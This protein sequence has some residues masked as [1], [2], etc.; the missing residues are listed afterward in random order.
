MAQLKWGISLDRIYLVFGIS[1]I[2]IGAC[3]I[4]STTSKQTDFRNIIT[5]DDEPGDADFTS[6]KEAVNYSSPGDTI[7]VYSG[8]YIEQGIHI[9]NDNIELLGISHELG[10]GND[11]G[12]PFI[13][14]DGTIAAIWIGASHVI[15]SNFSIEN[16]Y[17]HTH[18]HTGG[19]YIGKDYPP[20]EQDDIIIS[21]CNINNTPWGIYDTDAENIRIINNNISNCKNGI[22]IDF[23]MN[24]LTKGNVITDCRDCGIFFYGPIF[25]RNFSGNRIRNCEFGIEFGGRN[26]KFYDND[27]ENCSLGIR[28]SGSGNIFTRNNFKNYSQNYNPFNGSWFYRFFLYPTKNIWFGNYWDTWEGPG[29]KTILGSY[30]IGYRLIPNMPLFIPW[31]AFDWKPAK[32]PFDI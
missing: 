29:P 26:N 21:D 27:F 12:K 15:V 11:S 20:F 8:T 31:I 9:E 2:L 17:N 18:Y 32:E 24:F 7:E 3:I 10:E 14:G 23:S 4:P 22:N 13:K 19:I 28:C 5:V 16:P 1:L 6:I 30:V 25:N